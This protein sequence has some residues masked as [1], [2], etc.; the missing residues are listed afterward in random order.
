MKQFQKNILDKMSKNI[1]I[2][3]EFAKSVSKK[4]LLT[5]NHFNILK[6]SLPSSVSYYECLYIYKKL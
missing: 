6:M 5:T 4:S 3:Y 1:K 2:T